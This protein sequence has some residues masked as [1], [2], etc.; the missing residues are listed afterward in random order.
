MLNNMK[1]VGDR[2]H[3]STSDA[4]KCAYL[5]Q[6]SYDLTYEIPPDDPI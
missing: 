2:H 4:A 5:P 3:L 1:I 6:F